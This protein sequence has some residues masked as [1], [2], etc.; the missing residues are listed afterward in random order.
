MCDLTQREREV[1]ERVAAGQTSKAISD[2]LRISEPTVKWHVAK[3]LKKL[4]A[5]SRSEAVAVALRR[6][7]IRMQE[8]EE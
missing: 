4:G 3:V 6:G 8:R 5:H 7:Y 2:D 1:L